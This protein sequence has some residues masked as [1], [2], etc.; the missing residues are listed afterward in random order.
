MFGIIL[1][2][3]GKHGIVE[4]INFVVTVDTKKVGDTFQNMVF[5]AAS[6][7]F[8]S[9]DEKKIPIKQRGI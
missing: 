9:I 8:S 5:L 4:G 6:I 3:D 7:R 1:P 2:V